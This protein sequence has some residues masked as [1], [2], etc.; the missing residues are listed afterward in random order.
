[1]NDK[2]G[3]KQFWK[4][5]DVRF[6]DRKVWGS[7]P[8][9]YLISTHCQLLATAQTW[10]VDLGAMPRKWAPLTHDT[11]KGVKRV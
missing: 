10:S 2:L 7:K 3:E 11:W 9:A 1:M 5:Y 4:R 8:R 6:L